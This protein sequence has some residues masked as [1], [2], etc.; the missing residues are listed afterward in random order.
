VPVTLRDKLSYLL[1]PLRLAPLLV[2]IVFSVLLALAIQATLFGL[3]LGFLL[4]AG[5]FRYAF[6]LLD[7]LVVGRNDPPVLSIEMMHLVERHRGIPVLVFALGAFFGTGAALYWFS[8]VMAALVGLLVLGIVPAIVAVH[9][10]TASPVQAMNPWRWWQLAWRLG[11]DYL[12]A[13]AAVGALYLAAILAMAYLPRVLWLAI[14]LYAWLALF[15]LLGGLLYLRRDELQLDD[16]YE[17]E[18]IDP[19]ETAHIERARLHFLDRVYAESRSAPIKNA[20]QSVQTYLQDSDDAL[21]EL[22]WLYEHTRPWP[23]RR[24][25]NRI[26]QELIPKLLATRQTGQALDIARERLMGTPEFRPLA[27]ADLMRLA[28][29]ARDAGDRPTARR[30]LQDFSRFYPA[31]QANTAAAL[32]DQLDR[33]VD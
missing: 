29:L 2:I 30:L 4:T 24:L 1:V 7:Q 15:S 33:R 23:D 19:D 28:E 6:E 5:V 21:T 20:W 22:H 11:S 31:E 27:A 18:T 9:G 12:L 10:A 13:A 3:M 17:P 16:I 32:F 26:A 14:L 8:P 25:G